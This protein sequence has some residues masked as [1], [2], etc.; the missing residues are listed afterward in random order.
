MYVYSLSDVSLN[1]VSFF[2]E[3]LCNKASNLYY[4]EISKILFNIHVINEILCFKK[5]F[6]MPYLFL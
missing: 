6:K 5:L 2:G 4:S 3:I 1:I